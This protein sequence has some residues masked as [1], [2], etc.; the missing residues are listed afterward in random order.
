MAAHL[1][2]ADPETLAAGVSVDVTPDVAARVEAVAA[3]FVE[4]LIAAPVGSAAFRRAVTAIDGL[5]DRE[6][7]ATTEIARNFQERPAR[8]LKGLL[9]EGAP[10]SRNLARLRKAVET[11]ARAP[12]E[13]DRAE[14]LVRQVVEALD[15]NR[16]TLEEDNAAIAQQEVALWR[17]IQALREYAVLAARIDQLL[18]ERIASLAATDPAHSRGLAD[19][20]QFSIRRRRRDLLLQL[21]VATQGYAALRVIEQDNLEV[22]WAIRAATT[23]TA[24]ALRAAMLVRGA[25]A[26][27]TLA[28]KADLAGWKRAWS[29]VLGAVDQVDVR[30][31]RTL[32]EMAKPALA[33]RSPRRVGPPQ[34]S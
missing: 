33:E 13:M 28:G 8:A 6:I 30:K 14:G 17:E 22:I 4:R 18:D 24:T 3:P 21:A 7:R 2:E 9:G 34:R 12:S 16:Q 32:E 26:D 1:P 31:R 11:L 5:G 27:S 19:E 25:M 10:L 23:T 29:D 20:A 15:G